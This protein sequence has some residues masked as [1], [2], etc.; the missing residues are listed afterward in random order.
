MNITFHGAAQEIGRSCIEI[1]SKQTKIL[2]DAGLKITPEG[3]EYPIG[4]DDVSEADAI[5]VTH[6]HLDHTGALP[7]FDRFIDIVRPWVVEYF[8]YII[9]KISNI[10]VSGR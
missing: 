7:I 5:I 4:P 3:S 1:E 10:A 6:A 2:L 8:L 9:I